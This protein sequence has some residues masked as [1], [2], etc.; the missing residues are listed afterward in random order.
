MNILRIELQARI[1]LHKKILYR[2]IITAAT[3]YR[4][5]RLKK[6]KFLLFWYAN[7]RFCIVAVVVNVC[8]RAFYSVDDKK[9]TEETEVK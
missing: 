6:I 7:K 8:E 9:Q 3:A 2:Q 5:E 4:G 1:N